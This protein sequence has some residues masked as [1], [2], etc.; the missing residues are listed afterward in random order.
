MFDFECRTHITLL[1]AWLP[2]A[3]WSY[4]YLTQDGPYFSLLSRP[5]CS[6]AS[7]SFDGHSA[8]LFGCAMRLTRFLSFKLL[9]ICFLDSVAEVSGLGSACTAA[10]GPGRATASEPYWQQNIT[11]QGSSPYGPSGYVVFRNVKDYGAVGD[12]VTDDTVAIK[13][14]F[15]QGDAFI[16]LTI[17]SQRSHKRRRALWLRWALCVCYMRDY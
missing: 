12:G 6:I 2:F 10:L 3:L 1:I 7:I 16:G 13:C 5:L 8:I 9:V 17:V 11:H 14:C 4:I 15:L